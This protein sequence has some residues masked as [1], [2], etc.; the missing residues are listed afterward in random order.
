MRLWALGSAGAQTQKCFILVI[1]IVFVIEILLK[2]PNSDR[3][4]DSFISGEFNLFWIG[5]K[6]AF[7]SLLYNNISVWTMQVYFFK[8]RVISSFSVLTADCWQYWYLFHYSANGTFFSYDI[9]FKGALRDFI[10]I[11][12]IETAW[13]HS[14]RIFTWVCLK[15]RHLIAIY[16][17]FLAFDSHKIS[18]AGKSEWGDKII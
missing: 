14:Q 2:L 1:G 4:R 13:M 12:L 8:R 18:K 5:S 17:T 3:V 10:S 11:E 6:F 9:N 7:F 16:R 15:V